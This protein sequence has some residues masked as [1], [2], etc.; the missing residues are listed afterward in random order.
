MKAM[1]VLVVDDDHDFAEG[2]GDLI[3]FYGHAVDHANSAKCALAAVKDQYF[4]LIFLDIRM[5]GMSG[6]DVYPL[7]RESSPRSCIVF[8][9]AFMDDIDRRSNRQVQ[10]AELL[11]KPSGIRR[12]DKLLRRVAGEFE[13]LLVGDDLEVRELNQALRHRG[14]QVL[15]AST[16]GEAS[17]LVTSSAGEKVSAI[18]GP[19][20]V[21]GAPLVSLVSRLEEYGMALPL[22][23]V[24][25]PDG[26]DQAISKPDVVQRLS[27]SV[28]LAQV[29]ESVDLGA[30]LFLTQ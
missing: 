7:L 4:D 3:R 11:E 20:T 14:Y 5:P 29:L 23:S 10:H 15:R 27:A 2:L 28:S 24:N 9:T 13:V 16:L 21:N 26:T 8:A 1:S 30:D 6:L 25:D 17:E 12:L 19:C 22:I 18:V